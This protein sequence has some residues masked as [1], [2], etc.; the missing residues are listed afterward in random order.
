M[1][2]APRH[3]ARIAAMSER[4]DRKCDLFRLRP[5][6]GNPR[7]NV[8]VFGPPSGRSSKGGSFS[9]KPG[10]QGG[11]LNLLLVREGDGF[12]ADPAL[13]FT[14]DDDGP[15]VSMQL[16]SSD[17]SVLDLFSPP[18]SISN[19]DSGP[20]RCHLIHLDSGWE[21]SGLALMLQFSDSTSQWGRQK[22]R[23]LRAGSVKL[24]APFLSA[25]QPSA[26]WKV[27]RERRKLISALFVLFTRVCTH[28]P[29][30]RRIRSRLASG[31]K[32]RSDRF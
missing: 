7:R 26:R 30:H 5:F 12:D 16:D 6:L 18:L 1:S 9:A 24:Y 29:L 2:Q 13:L 27:S 15:S 11:L 21:T 23:L 10:F 22:T 17:T 8:C 31:G 4:D 28:E 20:R 14:E 25:I 3:S 32:G 19:H